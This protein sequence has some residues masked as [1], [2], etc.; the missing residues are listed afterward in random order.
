MLRRRKREE[1]ILQ[2]ETRGTE[3]GRIGRQIHFGNADRP[4]PADPLRRRGFPMGVPLSFVLFVTFGEKMSRR[5]VHAGPANGWRKRG[6]GAPDLTQPPG[7]SKDFPGRRWGTGESAGVFSWGSAL[8]HNGFSV[9]PPR[10]VAREHVSHSRRVAGQAAPFP[11]PA[12]RAGGPGG[13]RSAPLTSAAGNLRDGTDSCGI[14]GVG[15]PD[16]RRPPSRHRF[17]GC[18]PR[19]SAFVDDHSSR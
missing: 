18:A 6:G 15:L 3:V 12:A 17:R 13:E 14:T 11:A 19:P 7:R 5:L 9:R 2:E 4:H 8:A 1:D 10:E 16:R